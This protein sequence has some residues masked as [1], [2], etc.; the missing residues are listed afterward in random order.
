[1]KR[2]LC[3]L[4]SCIL[5]MALTA[6]SGNGKDNTS[7]TSDAIARILNPMEYTIYVNTFLNEQ[8]DDYTGKSY[9]KEGVFSILYDSFND[10]TRYYVW[11]YSDET[12]CCDWQWEFLPTDT[13][14]LPPIGSHVKMTGTLVQDDNAL[15]GYRFEK[16]TVETVSEYTAAAGEY[17]TTTMSPTLARVQL[18]NMMQFA[19]DYTDKSIKIY[20]R[21]MSGNKLQHPYYDGDWEI[22]LETTEK[23]PAIGTWVTVS[24]KFTGSMFEDSKIVVETVEIDE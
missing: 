4:L 1:M 19:P 20:G 23:L 5:L 11:G 17:D 16:A 24:G 8:G 12:L 21:V 9:T 13:A 2:K 10:T 6:C 3:T 15:D 18:V 22:P 7:G 14:S